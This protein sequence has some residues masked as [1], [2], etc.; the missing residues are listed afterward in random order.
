MGGD[1]LL[2]KEKRDF[3]LHVRELAPHAERRGGAARLAESVLALWLEQKFP[4]LSR[5]G[6]RQTKALCADPKVQALVDW[7][8]ENELHDSAFWLASAYAA[9][10]CEDIRRDRAMF[11]TPPI[12]SAR[13]IEDLA[14]NGASFTKGVFMDPACGGA[15]FLAPV[16]MRMR[17]ELKKKGLKPNAILEHIRTHLLGVDLDPTLCRLSSFF[18]KMVLYEDIVAAGKEPQFNVRPANAL[19]ELGELFGKID[20]ILCNPP[21]RKMPID[22]VAK[23]RKCFGTVIEGQPNLYGLFFALALELLKPNGTGALLTATSF[24]SGQYFSKL[25]TQL[26]K[27]ADTRQID[28]VGER[29]GV[30]VGVELETAITVFRKRVSRAAAFEQ[31]EVF[32][33]RQANGFDSIGFYALPNSG[34]AWPIPRSAGDAEAIRSANG[35]QFRLADYGYRPRIGAFVWN[36]DQ[37]KRFHSESAARKGAQAPFPLIWSSDV[38]QDGKLIFN[39]HKDERR[40]AFV[41]MGRTDHASVIRQ[42]CIALQRV[43]S[44]DQP[45]RL[46]AAPVKRAFIEKYG[47]VVGENHIVF[48]EQV[49][50]IPGLSPAQLAKVLRSQPIDGLFRSISGSTNVSAFELSQLPMPEPRAL[51]RELNRTSD[52]GAAVLRAFRLHKKQS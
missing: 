13:L 28:I 17:Q 27:H 40:D 43:T 2:P 1:A 42:P 3:Y 21:Y 20:V 31:T 33:P 26:L 44:N 39:R 30:F 35:S 45:R 16:A 5:I 50:K 51:A 36:R 4:K 37:R 9:W 41:D 8:A 7:L 23:Y 24:L 46:V 47:G 15:A 11:F 10:V 25:R 22:E 29:N 12:L 49:A 6:L 52:V 14:N 34:A 32:A 48:I 38:G 18:L 19:T